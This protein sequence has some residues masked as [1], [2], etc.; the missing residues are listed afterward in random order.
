MLSWTGDEDSLAATNDENHSALTTAFYQEAVQNI[1]SI[2]SCE[3]SDSDA[4]VEE[5]LF[6]SVNASDGSQPVDAQFSHLASC[7]SPAKLQYRWQPDTP[8]QTHSRAAGQLAASR[9]GKIDLAE[10]GNCLIDTYAGMSSVTE[11]EVECAFQ[12][13]VHSS[14]V[15]EAVSPGVQLATAIHDTEIDR[16]LQKLVC[17][18][19]E[20]DPHD[21]SSGLPP[22]SSLFT[23]SEA[24][25]EHQQAPGA[26]ATGRNA[27]K[28]A[29]ESEKAQQRPQSQ[30]FCVSNQQATSQTKT[31][32]GTYIRHRQ[33]SRLANRFHR[34]DGYNADSVA[35]EFD[36]WRSARAKLKSRS[37]Q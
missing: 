2:A 29:S 25:S 7:Q 3:D 28:L 30:Q 13:A 14:S 23:D 35:E 10:Q 36:D 22:A 32:T 20:Y 34:H 1:P 4:D 11:K 18:E 33:T 24:S 12:Q 6:S 27:L 26:S 8:V 37:Q 9:A 17:G 21:R 31:I 19:V 15:L 16:L 5:I